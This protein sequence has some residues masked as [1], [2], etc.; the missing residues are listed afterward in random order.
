MP[1]NLLLLALIKA[2]LLGILAEPEVERLA[3]GILLIEAILLGAVL[4]ES[5]Q[6]F[7]SVELFEELLFKIIF[8]HFEIIFVLEFRIHQV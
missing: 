6:V 1:S 5:Q 8:V 2:Q 7:V 4:V 3:H